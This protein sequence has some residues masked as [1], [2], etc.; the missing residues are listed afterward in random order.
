MSKE[1][2]KSFR[3]SSGFELKPAYTGRDLGSFEEA[4]YLGAPGEAPYTRGVYPSMYRGRFWTMRQY[5]GFGD[6]SETNRRFRYLLEHGQT[7]LSTAFDLPTQMGYDSDHPMSSGEVGKVGVAIDTVEDMKLLLDHIPLDQVS[8]SM[9]INS[10]AAILLSMYLVA[11]E[12]QGVSADQ[13]SGTIQNDLLKEYIARGTYIYPVKPSLRLTT[14]I[15]EFCSREVPSWNTISISGYHIREAGSTAVQ[16]LGFTLANAKVYVQAAVDKSLAVDSFAPRLSFFFNAH[17]NLFEE[18]AKFRAARR[19]WYRIMTEQFGAEDP[20][21]AKLRFHTQTAGSTLTAQQPHNNVV[22]TTVEALSAVLG[23]TQSL[24]TNAMDE[25]LGLPTEE[26]ARVALRTQQ[27]LAEESGVADVIDPLGGSYY[28]EHLTNR[29][30]QGVHELFGEIDSRGGMVACIESGW[31]QDQIHRSA[32]AWQ[33]AVDSGE[34]TVVGVNRYTIEEPSPALFTIDPELESAQRERLAK[35]KA[36]RD[37]KAAV[38][39]LNELKT[40]AEGEQNLVPKILHAVRARAS[41]GEISDQLRGVF[42]VYD[43]K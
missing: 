3:V 31:V 14:D 34:E 35:V 29:L 17:S 38:R 11:A 36:G 21:S 18:V 43:S 23:G 1:R 2:K 27:I 12:E 15:F 19:L 10:T 24:H 42:G 28:V 7:G 20:R 13:V 4:E 5:A 22:R 33:Q 32:Y 39:A 6:A 40:A 8:T 30:E 25:A 41:V 16:E 37:E 26:A 9:T